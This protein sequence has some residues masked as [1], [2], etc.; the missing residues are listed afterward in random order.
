M[1]VQTHCIELWSVV[2][3]RKRPLDRMTRNYLIILGMVGLLIL[4][5]WLPSLNPRVWELN[6]LL[7]TDSQLSHYPY[8]FKVIE[9]DGSS[10]TLSSP[11][12]SK[13]AAIRFLNILYPGLARKSPNHPDVIKAQKELASVQ[14]H[15]KKLIMAQPEIKSVQW[16]V[17]QS[18]YSQHGIMLH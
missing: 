11:R 17:D 15:A 12:S 8:R 5:A 1:P 7:E 18:W 4:F 3:H 9:I 10:A 16:R 2:I 14:K 6:K 13:V